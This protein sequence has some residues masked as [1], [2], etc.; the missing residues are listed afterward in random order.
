MSLQGAINTL[1]LII[2]ESFFS[3]YSILAMKKTPNRQK[4]KNSEKTL[5]MENRSKKS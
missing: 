2:Q 5:K 1:H 3:F 4:D